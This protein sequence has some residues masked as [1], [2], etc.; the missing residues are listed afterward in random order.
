MP[1]NT[2]SKKSWKQAADLLERRAAR[3]IALLQREGGKTLDDALSEVREASDFCRYY[4]AQGRDTVRR[5]MTRPWRVRPDEKQPVAAARPRR[6]CQ[7]SSPWFSAGDF[8]RPGRHAA[9]MAGNAV[10]AKPASGRR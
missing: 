6:V 1:S 4:A 2:R 9:V 3:F 8:Y 7:R 5:N 10:V